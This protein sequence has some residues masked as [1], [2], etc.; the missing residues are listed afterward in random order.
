M[1][2]RP[3][4]NEALNKRLYDSYISFHRQVGNQL[5]G[6][7]GE[8]LAAPVQI[9]IMSYIK[10]GTV[11]SKDLAIAMGYTPSAVAQ[12][13]AI[14]EQN[15]TIERKQTLHDKRVLKLCLTESGEALLAECRRQLSVSLNSI[16]TTL[17]K[18][19]LN[20]FC[21]LFEKLI[22]KKTV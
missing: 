9:E 20:N 22:S 12:Q 3:Q 18:E 14:L 15:G 2:K 8:K 19:E 21:K 17:S 6:R 1:D 5:H 16:T 11:H 10:D 4:K 7:L 13:I